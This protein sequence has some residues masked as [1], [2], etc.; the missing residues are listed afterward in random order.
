VRLTPLLVSVLRVLSVHVR[1][2]CLWLLTV[3]NLCVWIQLGLRWSI[4][5][6]V[7]CR[8]LGWVLRILWRAGILSCLLLASKYESDIPGA[9]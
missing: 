6:R 2:E 3:A 5:R 1:V 8:C 7:D 4:L 9:P